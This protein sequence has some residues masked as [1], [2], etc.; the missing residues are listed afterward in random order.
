MLQQKLGRF[1]SI[2]KGK[3]SMESCSDMASLRDGD[4][5]ARPGGRRP[6]RLV[7]LGLVQLPGLLVLALAFELGTRLAG[8]HFPA[9]SRAGEGGARGLWVY[10]A[11]LGWY[12]SPG[13]RGRSFLG[14]PDAG[15]VRLNAL[16]LRGREVPEPKP[17]GVRRVL[18]LGDSFAFGVGVDEA[19]LL[20]S[21]LER[22][23]NAA[24][25]GVH[26]VVNLGVA[27]YATD[28]E[29]LLLRRLGPRLSPDG[30]VL[31]LCDNDLDGNRLDF[32][33]LR[34]YK[35]RF[36]LGADSRPVLDA[37]PVRRLGPGQRVKLWLAERSNLWNA[38]RSRRSELAP[39]QA[40]LGWFQVGE[41]RASA[42]DPIE[43]AAALVRAIREEAERLGA[44][45]VVISTGHRGED[46]D[47]IFALR[48]RLRADG[49][50]L[51]RMQG[52]LGA[53]RAARP[54]GH[55]DFPSDHHWNVDAHRLV[56]ET[57]GGELVARG[58]R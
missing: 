15:E 38:L 8:V 33:Y 11:E 31:V 9:I 20:S 35:P 58:W 52:V 30:I 36:A 13:A 42:D 40:A 37:L 53:A 54:D 17:A 26:E 41:A 6:A 16:G 49:I 22:R 1:L 25:P 29:L 14:G 46:V 27:G 50:E 51:R 47:A 4:P 44:P 45:L 39:L 23:L 5:A 34:Y 43:L 28:Q 56:G 18:V 2:V 12:H 7:R 32:A 55:W 24:L 48:R 57:L 3:R 21:V 10:D 19:H